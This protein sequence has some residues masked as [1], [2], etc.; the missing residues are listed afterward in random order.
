M[1][2]GMRDLLRAEAEK[3]GRSMNA[4]VV[5][6]LQASLTCVL[7]VEARLARIEEILDLQ[8]KSD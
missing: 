4:E 7:G 5:A 3:A 6:Q 8:R 2:E 1:P